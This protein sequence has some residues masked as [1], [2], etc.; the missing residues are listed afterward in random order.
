MLTHARGL[1][2]PV[3]LAVRHVH[4]PE[5]AWDGP[6]VGVGFRNIGYDNIARVAE[7]V[8][9]DRRRMADADRSEAPVESGAVAR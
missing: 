2:L 4:T 7:L 1:S 6:V 5:D 8:D 9:A 3:H